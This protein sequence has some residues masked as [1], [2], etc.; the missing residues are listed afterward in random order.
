MKQ[1]YRK[2]LTGF[3]LILFA[4]SWAEAYPV[5]SATEKAEV[6]TYFPQTPDTTRAMPYPIPVDDGNP[7]NQINNSSPLYLKDPPNIKREIVYDPL[8]GQY[9]FLSKVGDFTYRT[10]TPMSQ[11]DYLDFQ[12]RQSNRAYF[13]DRAKS[14]TT[15]TSNSIIPSIYVGG[16]AFDRIFGGNTIDIRPQGT[17]EVSFGIKSNKRDDP[18]LNVRQ[19]RT[20]NFDFDQKIQMNV[21]A[22]IGDK[23]EFKTNYNTEATFQFENR[24]QLKYEGKEDEVIKLIE[25][26]NVSLP[27]NT[28][29]ING[30]QAL[31]GIKTK[32]QFGRTTVTAVFSQQESESKNITVQGGAQTSEFKMSSLDYEENRHFFISQYFRENYEKALETLPVVTSDINITKVEVWVTNI[33]P[34]LEDNRNI[35]AFTDL[36]EGREEWIYNDQVRASFGPALPTN[37]SNNLMT[38]LDTNAIRNINTV[39]S[40]LSGDPLR[41]GRTGYFVAGQDFEKVEN[42][43]KLNPSEYTFNGKLGFISLNTT[44][45]S[46]QTLAVAYQYTVIGY[47]STFQVGEF[48]DQGINAPKVLSA[49]L[50]KSTTLNTNMPMWDLMMKNVYSMRAFQVNREDFTFNILY[51]GNQNGVPTGYFTEGKDDVK[52]IP[53]IHLMNLDNLNQQDNPVKGGDGVF[54]FLDNAATQGGTINAANGRIF[55]TVLEPFGS[56]IRNK[57]FPD[58]PDL[59]DRYAYDSLY[60]VTKAAAEQYPEKNKFILEGF[61]KSQS[62][63][64]INLNALNVPQG[65]VKVTAGGVPL[66]ENV[67]YTVDYTLG[68]VRIINEGILSSG[69]PININLES[70]SLFSLQQK[71]MMGLRVDHEINRDFRIG[72]TLLNL[73]ERPLTQKVNYGDDPISNTIYG[74]DL[75]YRTESRWLTRMIDKLP[76]ISTKQVSKINVDAEFAHFLPGHARAVGKTGTSYIDDFEGAKSTIDLRQVNT[77]FLASTPQGQFD[78]FPE[79]APN[80]G[81]NYGKNRAKLAWYIID[82]LF[83]DRYGTL[84]PSNVDRNELSKNSVRQV[85]ETEVFPN[86]DI[87][88]GTP[89]NIPILNLAYYPQERGPYNYDVMPGT[90][91]DGINEDGT[92]KSPESRWGGIMRRIESTD[93]EQTNIEYLEFWMMDP[94]SEEGENSG[95]LYI[96]LGD[97][98]EDIL[99]DGRKSYE[100]G[101]PVSEV[102]E[103]VDTTIWGRVPSLQALVEAFNNDPNSRQYQDIGYDGLNDADEADFHAPTFLDIIREQY[104]T[105]SLAYQQAASDPSA[106]NYQYFRGAALDADSR[107]SSI[108]E[109]YKSFNGPEGNSPS[110]EQNPEAYPTSATS[111]PNVEDINRD[112]TL[113]EAERYFQYRIK[114]D[115]NNMKVGENFIADIHDAKGI[116]LANGEVGEVKWYQFRIPISQPEKVVGN[117]EDFR[118]IRFMRLFMRGFE[119]PVVLRFATLELVRGE[120]RKYRQNL[121]APGEYVVGDNGNETKFDISAVNLEENGRREPIPYVI[122][123]GIDQEINFGTTSLVRLNEQSMQMTLDK[124]LDGDARAAFKTTDFDFRQYKKLKMYVHAEKLY[125]NEELNYGDLTVFVRLG[126][127]FTENYY[128]YEVPLTFTPWGTP[129][130]DKEGIWPAAN[131]FDIDLDQLVKVKQNRNM[132]MRNPNSDISLIYPYMEQLGDHIVKVIGNPSISDVMGIMIGV[133]NPKQLS[134]SSND[135]GNPKSAIIWVNELR[136]TDFNNKGG[137]AATARIETLL[138]DVGRVVV[139]GSHSTPGFGSLDMKVNET[140]REAVTNF[141]VATDIDLGKFLPEESGVRVPMHF[142]YGES[143]IKPEYN[144]LNPDIKMKDEL[145]VLGNKADQDSLKTLVNDYTQRKNINFVNVRKDRTSGTRQ[146]RIYDIE[147]WNVSYSYSEI[148]HRNIDIEYDI[149]QTYRGGLGY[150]FTG[151]PKNVQPFKSSKWASKPFMQLIK[152]FNF[153]YLPKNFAFRTDMNRQYNEKKFRNKSEGEIITY[154]IFAKQWDWNRYYDFKFD[155]TRSL[156]FDFSA[157]ANAFIYE[158][159]GNPERGTTEWKMNRDTIWDEVLSFGT[160]TRYNQSVRV[161]YTV[162]INKIPLLNWVTVSAGYQGGYTWLASP[163]SVQERIG[164][165]IENQNTKQLNGNMDFVKLYNKIGYLKTLNTPQ[166]SVGRGGPAPRPGA[167]R[168]GAKPQEEEGN[169]D[170]TNTKPAVNYFKI[171]AD[172]VLKL[173]MSV[174]KANLNY[175]QNNGMFLPGFLPEP[176]IFGLNLAASAPGVGFVLGDEADIRSL[177]VDNDWLTR[178]S[179]LNRAFAKK[180][181]ETF[182]YKINLEPLPGL[183]IDINADRTYARNFQEYFRADSM[184]VFQS[185]S[186]TETGNFSMSYGMWATSFVKARSDESSELFDKLLSNRIEIANRLAYGNAKWVEEGESY[187]YDSVGQAY[188]PRGYGAISPQVVL[189]SFLAAYGGKNPKSISLNPFPKTPIPNW[190]INYNGLTKI[191]FIQRLFKTVNITHA[192]RSAYSINTWRTNVD[193][194]PENTT[195]TYRNSNMFIPQYDIGQVTISEQFAPLIGVDLGLHN[196]L[197]ARIEYKKQRNLTLSFINNQLTEVVGDEIIIGAGYRLRNLSFIVSSLTGGNATRASNDLILKLDL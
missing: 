125:E 164:N 166:R 5:L 140:A 37:V 154:P 90:F 34:A 194:D 40:Y 96:N 81:L 20:T 91:T 7:M 55:F 3:I 80:T 143:H 98:S 59:A 45:N 131:D 112:N 120:W 97:I 48:S 148:Y 36:G 153:Y 117:I 126:S 62:G 146:P 78:L 189:Y 180:F 158:P 92:L 4:F 66:T 160:K 77:W 183:R 9:I 85:L 162:P 150:N 128:E 167:V 144:P 33:G 107:Y 124:L 26:G 141:D 101:L 19:R 74:I 159:A 169:A 79:A 130:T 21:I 142:D 23:I 27:L 47:D 190:T 14:T 12:G 136:V 43:R 155:L 133:R 75:S 51:T 116:P 115:P 145:D 134:L 105:Q 161:N 6:L 57:I 168:P 181:T 24:L 56:Y 70:N 99:R 132:A 68:R 95:E 82:Q 122:P 151:N 103:N 61:Y 18:Q 58:D 186:P 185:F 156:T 152:D 93:F 10:P 60:A 111:L 83:Y 173:V 52:G 25:A 178:D 11:E 175:T 165:S 139:S 89:T 16:E 193:Y 76:G 196:S 171:V 176:D 179:L 69:T 157:G 137:W 113:S 22:K 38:R 17:A 50:L 71:R 191:P 197:T 177:A 39:T 87:P 67:D 46:D 182:S 106:D 123:P 195:K 135:D 63:S 54:D 30:S 108:L 84:R 28:T 121:Q 72:G 184:G 147:N 1:T 119:K 174:K 31:F 100:N 64:E 109:R 13:N 104:G 42:A 188:Y 15:E 118:S 44:L 170:S 187:V 49:K 149:R 32:L 114:L 73:H 102:I 172:Q 65:S 138:A 192:Y 2:I 53:L 8:T 86:K 127:D 110:D 35:L 94:F 163:L 129:F 29:L 41:I 88:S